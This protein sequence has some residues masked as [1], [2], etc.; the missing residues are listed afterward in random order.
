MA[1]VKKEVKANDL[2]GDGKFDRADKK[3]AAG[4]LVQKVGVPAVPVVKQEESVVEKGR[5]A[6]VDINLTYRTG[7]VVP[8]SVI[9]QWE[10][11][12]IDTKPFFG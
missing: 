7:M 2:N 10:L 5:V 9:K 12:G 1:R 3:I 11:M 4:V 6:I 8:A